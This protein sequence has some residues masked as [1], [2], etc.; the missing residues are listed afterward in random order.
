MTKAELI[1][2]VAE[3]VEGVSK[4]DVNAVYEAIFETIIRALKEDEKHRYQVNNFG[5]FEL[6]HRDARKGRNPATGEQIDIPAQ[7]T[8]AFRPAAS[9]KADLSK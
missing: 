8:I 9:V 1:E 3:K 7:T 6:K 4:T 5:T 2:I